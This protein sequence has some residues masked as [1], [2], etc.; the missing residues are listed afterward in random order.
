MTHV[1]FVGPSLSAEQVRALHPQAVVY[2][3][4]RQ[5]DIVSVLREHSPSAIGI[6]DGVFLDVLSVWH[7]EILLAL[8]Q[9][10]E[11]F[12]AASMGALRA[13]ECAR[14]GMVGIGT[15]YEMYA[16]G[17]LTRDDEVAVAHSTE[18]FGFRSLSEPL[19]NIRLNLAR[20][21]EAG[22]LT[23]DSASA[24]LAEATD[25]YFPD[26]S[27]AHVFNSPELDDSTRDALR[28]FITDH[29]VDYKAADAA[30]LLTLMASRARDEVGP[31]TATST[32]EPWQLER[33]HYLLAI[34]E[35]DRWSTRLGEQVGQESIYRFIMANDPD[36]PSRMEQSLVELLA[37]YAAKDLGITPDAD[38]IARTRRE[39]LAELRLPESALAQYC[40]DCDIS[41]DEFDTLVRDRARVSKAVDWLMRTRFKLGAV[42]PV[43]NSYRLSGAY[44][45]WADATAMAQSVSGRGDDGLPVPG[46]PNDA[47]TA[48]ILHQHSTET[49]WNTG[50]R[51]LP[52]WVR[53][54]GFI[55]ERALLTEVQRSKAYRQMMAAARM[56][57]ESLAE[58]TPQTD[59]DRA[60]Q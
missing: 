59:N 25:T 21:T 27:W 34:S 47:L 5:G 4:A 54:H 60:Q 15:V 56:V 6:I 44:A 45:K 35:R 16:D 12:G 9:G 1:V 55:H 42:Q 11:V 30:S 28:T 32:G 52:E 48:T 18:E 13:A 57:G 3:P 8:D 2:P 36:A 43:L 33:S 31:Q 26:R 40:R 41:L 14:F 29:G 10:V 19:V 51:S 20:A 24:L 23:E 39:V 49:G 22:V 53:H 46:E 17:A 7:K 58:Q 37:Q 50:H 38:D